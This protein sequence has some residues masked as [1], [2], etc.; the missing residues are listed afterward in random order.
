MKIIR[1]GKEYFLTAEELED[2]YREQKRNY[3]LEDAENQ[4]N[5]FLRIRFADELSFANCFGFTCEDVCEPDSAYYL[6]GKFLD[7]Y[8]KYHDC[9]QAENDMWQE[10]ILNV[11]IE[12]AVN[13]KITYDAHYVLHDVTIPVRAHKVTELY[14][15][16]YASVDDLIA[17]EPKYLAAA[18]ER[19]GIRNGKVTFIRTIKEIRNIGTGIPPL[20][21]WRF[22]QTDKRDAFMVDGKLIIADQGLHPDHTYV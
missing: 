3:Q 19:H 8:E 12:N 15:N 6:L 1:A 21:D 2:A 7:T 18:F 4:F 14:P 10:V 17:A 11:L 22:V 5:D 20:R 9:E 13:V 16:G